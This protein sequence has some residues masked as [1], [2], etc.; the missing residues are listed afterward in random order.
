MK[1]NVLRAAV[2]ALAAGLAL[3]AQAQMVKVTVQ[4]L[5]PLTP[6]GLYNGPLWLGFHNG[7]FDSFDSG[8]PASAAIERLAELGD[9]SLLNAAFSTA[10]PTGLSLVLN[11]PGGPGP[12]IYTPGSSN[13]VVLHLDAAEQRYLSYGAM[14]VPSNDTFVANGNPTALALFDGAGHFLGRQSWTLTG[15][16]TWD[17]GT[18]VNSPTDG[19]A[20]VAGVDAMLGTVE[21]GVIHAQSLTALDNTIGLMTPAG[22]TIGQGLSTAP[23]LRISVTPVPEPGTYGLAAALAL[24]TVVLWRRRRT[25]PAA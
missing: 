8:T 3:S 9:S 21:G 5:S 14:V 19:A 25:A 12:G 13:S 16:D 2:A 4:N 23:L 20:F 18:E 10:V 7:S 17:S 6:T 11:N 22:T 1:S 15:A 24:A